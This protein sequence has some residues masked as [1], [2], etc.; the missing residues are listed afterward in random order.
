MLKR[1]NELKGQDNND[2]G[3]DRNLQI[4]GGEMWMD[5]CQMRKMQGKCQRRKEI[6]LGEGI[7]FFR[8]IQQYDLHADIFIHHIILF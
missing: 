7:S 3:N 8:S 2:V 5:E 6:L 1:K 4:G